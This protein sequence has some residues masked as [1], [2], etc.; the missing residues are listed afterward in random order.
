[1]PA[2]VDEMKATASLPQ[3]AAALWGKRAVEANGRSIGS[4]VSP[5]FDVSHAS[6]HGPRAASSLQSADRWML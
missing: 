4:H 5:V 2:I 1:M 3:R 6:R